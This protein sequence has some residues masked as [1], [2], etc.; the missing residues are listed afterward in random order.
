MKATAWEFRFRFWIILAI[1]VLGFTTPWD[2]ALAS[3]WL[4]AQ[5]ACVGTGWRRCCRE[6]GASHRRGVQCGAGGGDCLCGGGSVAAD[7]GRGVP[8]VRRDAATGRCAE[9]SVVAGGSVS[10]SA[11]PAVPGE[12]LNTLALALLMTAK[13][14][15]VHG[16]GAGRDFSCG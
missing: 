2:L 12:W 14:G 1:F 6:S 9:M 5:C 7:M 10:L 8:G 15:G 16:A 11:E 13:R 3:G 4:R